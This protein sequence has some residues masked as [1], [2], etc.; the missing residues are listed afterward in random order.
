MAYHSSRSISES[1]E[2]AAPIRNEMARIIRQS[3]GEHL[4]SCLPQVLERI[5]FKGRWIKCFEHENKRDV[6]GKIALSRING[7][8]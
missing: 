1:P 4:I 6:V 2:N 8:T 5:V 7:S 3:A